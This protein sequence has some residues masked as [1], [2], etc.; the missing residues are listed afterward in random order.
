MP[1][2]EITQ[3]YQTLFDFANPTVADKVAVI[4]DGASIEA[5][6]SE[7]LASTLATSATGAKVNNI[8][9]LDTSGCTQAM[10]PSPCASVTY[11]ILG[12]SGT[13]IL[14]NN[15]GYAVSID[16]SW[17]V[18]TKTVCGLLGLFYQATGKTGTPPGC[19]APDSSTPTTISFGA[20]T[21]G[22]GCATTAR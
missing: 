21:C 20:K 8:S 12:Q 5:G 19:P 6:L 7:A 15:Q 22:D 3:A 16:G 13:A 2:G 1:S 4:Q 14:P 11:D 10:L 9:F 17:L 18:A